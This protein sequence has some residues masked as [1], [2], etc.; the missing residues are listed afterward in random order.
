MQKMKEAGC[1]S[2]V[3]GVQHGSQHMVEKMNTRLDLKKVETIANIGK[4]LGLNMAAFLIVA[5]PG[6]TLKIF[7]ESLSFCMRIG[8]KYGINDWRINVARAY[9]NTHLYND[10]VK[11]NWFYRDP[12]ELLYFPG[13]PTEANI[14]CPE[15]T[16]KEALRRRDY[17]KRKLMSVENPFYWTFVYYVEWL[18]LKQVAQKILP[19]KLWFA[20]KKTLFGLSFPSQ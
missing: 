8:R 12:S 19:D 9:P 4:E 11:N 10:C 17:A 5:Y 3:L 13:D 2:L 15:F 20:A 16:P 6:E 18:G 14:T 1:N 7:K